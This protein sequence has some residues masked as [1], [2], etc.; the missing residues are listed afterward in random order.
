MTGFRFNIYY[1]QTIH[2]Y[3]FR[4]AS[5]VAENNSIDYVSLDQVLKKW[6]KRYRLEIGRQ[7]Q[8]TNVN[9]HVL[10]T[11][12]IYLIYIRAMINNPDFFFLA[13]YSHLFV[14][15]FFCFQNEV[16]QHGLSL[17]AY[18]C[19]DYCVSRVSVVNKIPAFTHGLGWFI[20]LENFQ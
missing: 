17:A 14:T 8:N 15:L 16:I 9:L 20:T 7:E 19:K 6:R 2:I 11:L 10:H 3:N 5:F 4:F 12:Y 13:S 18:T 1:L